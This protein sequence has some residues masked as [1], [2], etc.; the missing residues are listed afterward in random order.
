VPAAPDREVETMIRLRPMV[1]A[2][3]PQVGRWLLL[4]HVARWWTPETT[5]QEQLAKYRRRL[6]GP[7]R[8]RMLTVLADGEPIGW[9]Q[10]YRWADY[11]EPAAGVDAEPTDVGIDYAIGEPRAVGRGLGTQVIAALVT[12]VRRHEPDA[13]I[14]STPEAENTASRRV[15]EGNGFALV[16]VR[17]ISTEG[18]DR[19]MAIYRLP[20]PGSDASR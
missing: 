17:S 6:D 10:W 16:S 11:P 7:S 20:P 15:L 1:D 12:E 18:H 2:D 19:P 8:T 9:C 5:P 13:A 14:R 4:P 3:L